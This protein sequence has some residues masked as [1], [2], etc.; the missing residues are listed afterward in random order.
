MPVLNFVILEEDLK[1][2][3]FD[4]VILYNGVSIILNK[5]AG[6]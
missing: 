1:F 5:E 4:E 3:N 2:K 6:K